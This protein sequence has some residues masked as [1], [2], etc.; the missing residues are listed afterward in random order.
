ML[1]SVLQSLT[2][3]GHG[4][5][6]ALCSRDVLLILPCTF[7]ISSIFLGRD[8]PLFLPSVRHTKLQETH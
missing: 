7:M 2:F 4:V 8:V 1:P 5:A 3:I 6:D